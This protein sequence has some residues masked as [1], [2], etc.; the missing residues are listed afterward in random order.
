MRALNQDGSCPVELHVDPQATAIR[1]RVPNARFTAVLDHLIANAREAV[2]EAGGVDRGPVRLELG[3]TGNAAVID[4][5]DR[6]CGMTPAFVAGELFKPFRSTK[7]DG[8]GMGAYQCRELAR[9]LGGDLEV[10]STPAAGTT[11][12]L[13]VPCAP[14]RDRGAPAALPSNDDASLETAP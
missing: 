12:R 4:V 6:G 2:A 13:S 10:L 7:A 14:P 1:V 9:E 11:M 5:V 8:L 3:K